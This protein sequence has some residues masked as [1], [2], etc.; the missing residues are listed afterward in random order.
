M[1]LNKIRRVAG[2]AAMVCGCALGVGLSSQYGSAQGATSRYFP[3]TKHTV[4]GSFLKYWEGHG[5]LSQQGFPISEEFTEVS[6]LDGKPYTVQYF[7][8]AV[9]E[10]HPENKVPFDVLLSQLGTFQYK[11]KY[12]DAGAPGQQANTNGGRLFK[13]TGYY[14][15]SVFLSYWNTHGGLAQQGF[16]IS[17]EFTETSALDGKP[18]TVQYF[19]RAVFERHPENKPPYDVLLSQLGTFQMGE[20]YPAGAPGGQGQPGSQPTAQPT[21]GAPQPTG[22]PRKTNCEAV[23]DSRKSAIGHAG[24]VFI[25]DVHFENDDE[26]VELRNDSTSGVAIGGW[27]LRDKNEPEQKFVFPAGVQIG[28]GETIKVYTASGEGHVYSFNSRSPIW[29]NCGDA[30]ELLDGNGATVATYAYGTHLIR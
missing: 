8:R 4:A 12:S 28:A 18:Y 1:F 17:N 7:E 2:I 5:G 27:V 22:T 26:H 14:V 20:K 16:P 29:N 6:D 15:G 25:S 13:E 24:Q 9:F 21:A 3:E 30:L 23:A 19:E 10:K 11:A